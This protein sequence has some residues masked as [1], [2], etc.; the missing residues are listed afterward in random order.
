[1][2]G[3]ITRRGRRDIM[4]AED[5]K[6]IAQRYWDLWN[7]GNLASIEEIFA[8]DYVF[9]DGAGVVSRGTERLKRNIPL[10]RS[11]V[12]DLR[13][14]LE[15]VCAEENKVIVRWTAHGTHRGDLELVGFIPKIPATGKQVTFFGI[16]LYRIMGDKIVESWRSW[17]R[18]PLLQQLG[19]VPT[20]G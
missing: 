6:A 8:P 7:T 10:W 4:S 16:D 1:V 18:L 17:D 9:H 5:N 20:A 13:F 2:Q 12:P 11:A 14:V 15:D 3:I 19:V